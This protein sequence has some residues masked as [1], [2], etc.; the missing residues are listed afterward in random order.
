MLKQCT[1]LNT[2]TNN[3]RNQLCFPNNVVGIVGIDAITNTPTQPLPSN[4]GTIPSK[5]TDRLYRCIF[6]NMFN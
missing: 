4:H 6:V 3:M 5:R 2:K 1:H